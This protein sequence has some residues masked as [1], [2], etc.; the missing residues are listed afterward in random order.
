MQI[1]L[2]FIMLN[3]LNFINCTVLY[4]S[5]NSVNFLNIIFVLIG[6]VVLLLIVV[7]FIVD[8]DPFGFFRYSFRILKVSYLQTLCFNQ[9]ILYCFFSI[10][11]FSALFSCS[12]KYYFPIRFDSCLYDLHYCFTSIYIN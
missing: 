7:K 3:L 9:S 11:F 4:L 6:F 8:P 2:Y 5:T 12:W 10:S 1:T